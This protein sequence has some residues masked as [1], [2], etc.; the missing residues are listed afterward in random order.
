M[1]AFLEWVTSGARPDLNW[2]YALITL[3]FRF[4]AVFVVL[5]LIQ[6]GLQLSAYLIRRSER[7]HDERAPHGSGG[8]AGAA[9]DARAPDDVTLDAATV[10]AIGLALELEGQTEAVRIASERA[11]SPWAMAGR[12]RQLRFR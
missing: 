8:A 6:A 9:Q 12:A 11:P 5:W 10:A 7:S 1:D 2:T 3:M 4:V